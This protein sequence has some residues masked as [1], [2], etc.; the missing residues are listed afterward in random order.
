MYIH[1][2]IYTC[3]LEWIYLKTNFIVE[4]FR[5]RFGRFYCVSY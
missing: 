2:H 1:T 3:A 5:S 4:T